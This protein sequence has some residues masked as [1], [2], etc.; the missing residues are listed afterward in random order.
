MVDILL[1][2]RKMD[3]IFGEVPFVLRYD[4]KEGESKMNIVQTIKNT[5]G[6]MAKR[7]MGG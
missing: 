2:L 6:L 4:M 7:W 5:L 3:L 1:K